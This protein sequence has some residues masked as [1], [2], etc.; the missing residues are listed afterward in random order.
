MRKEVFSIVNITNN[1]G[2][3]DLQFRKDTRHERTNSPT[4]YRWKAQFI[5]TTPVINIKI[6]NNIAKEFGCGNVSASKSQA[7]FSVQKIDDIINIIIPYFKKNNLSGKKKNDFNLWEKGVKII[8]QNKGKQLTSWKKSDL[9]QLIEIQKS[10][11][12]YKN[13][14]RIP[15]WFEMAQVISRSF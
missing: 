7:R 2:C 10:G 5:I 13:N 12:K 14:P 11:A 6:L 9:L 1:D 4:Y 15:K 8:Y 3:F